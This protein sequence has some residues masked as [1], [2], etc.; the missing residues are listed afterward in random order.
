MP[1][2]P[3]APDFGTAGCYRP[4]SALGPLGPWACYD[5]PPGDVI[6][7]LSGSVVTYATT[8]T[9]TAGYVSTSTT[10]AVTA[11]ASGGSVTS[12]YA[13]SSV[14]PTSS[15]ATSP[16]STARGCSVY[17]PS[18]VACGDGC[19]P[20]NSVCCLDGG[21]CPSTSLCSYNNRFSYWGC[22]PIGE[23]CDGSQYSSATSRYFVASTSATYRGTSPAT[24]TVY[25][26]AGPSTDHYALYS[27]STS[28]SRT[29]T[30]ST[31]SSSR[32][33]STAAVGAT[34]GS[35]LESAGHRNLQSL[36]QFGLGA[37][38]LL[39]SL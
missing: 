36:W 1:C 14:L 6:S 29:T 38:G 19:I 21:Y 31:G 17:G 8:S 11:L 12:A 18:W 27:S 34:A 5:Y 32:A 33:S 23:D 22:C 24:V 4:A 25:G 13:A 16:T 35:S 37:M 39:L 28:T 26:G 30:S 15:Y 2:A 10:T 7:T 3:S 9:S 20:I